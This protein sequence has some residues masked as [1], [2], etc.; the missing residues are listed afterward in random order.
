MDQQ[1]DGCR[2]LTVEQ[3]SPIIRKSVASIRSD[4]GRNPKTLPPICRLP[5]NKKLL[6]REQDVLEW[7]ERHVVRID[8]IEADAGVAG[9]SRRPSAMPWEIQKRRGRPTK[10]ETMRRA[11]AQG[12]AA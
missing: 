4:V 9:D 6:W 2:L 5:G 11:A 3:L 1:H 10:I 12:G 7:I 8:R